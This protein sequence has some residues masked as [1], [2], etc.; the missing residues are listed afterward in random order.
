MSF[1]LLKKNSQDKTRIDK[2][3]TKLEAQSKKNY[4]DP[5]FWNL[6]KDKDGNGT[7]VIRFL[8]VAAGDQDRVI[9][10]VKIFYHSF[11]GK[12][13]ATYWENCLSSIGEYDS[14]PVNQYN[15]KLWETQDEQLQR[16]VKE[17]SKRKQKII[18]NILVVND[19]AVPENNGKVFKCSVGVKILE[20]IE[21]AMKGNPTLK[22]KGFDPFCFWKGADFTY[23]SKIVD[24]QVT[25]MDSAFDAP[26]PIHFLDEEPMS[27][28]QIEELVYSKMYK[29]DDEL[30]P[31]KFKSYDELKARL[32]KVLGLDSDGGATEAVKSKTPAKSVV[33]KKTN[34]KE[35][36][37]PVEDDTEDE[38]EDEAEDTEDSK[39]ENS[40]S[41]DDVDAIFKDL[42]IDM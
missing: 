20:K 27:D 7:A 26:S 13:G 30:K 36:S 12:T 14:D 16:W 34:L 5:S 11:K 29:L 17:N 40:T 33:E 9:P 39:S 35:V 15:S 24:K 6:T 28:E 2:L 32:N 10:C 38:S 1:K 22:K 3:V 8:P 42:E 4:S 41:E 37:K 21:S 19:P 18:F 25:Y 23:T 31:E